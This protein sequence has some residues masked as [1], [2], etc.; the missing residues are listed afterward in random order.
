M[1]F[2]LTIQLE[3]KPLPLLFLFKSLANV[4]IILPPVVELGF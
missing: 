4:V 1:S 2:L 3:I